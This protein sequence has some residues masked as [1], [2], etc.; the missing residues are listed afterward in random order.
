MQSACRKQDQLAS[1]LLEPD[2]PVRVEIAGVVAPHRRV[3]MCVDHVGPYRGAFWDEDA[4]E[5]E[6]FQCN[7]MTYGYGS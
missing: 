7:P 6:V 2:E 4:G 1:V 3:E 5:C